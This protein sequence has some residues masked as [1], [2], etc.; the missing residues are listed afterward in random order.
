[1]PSQPKGFLK[2]RR[3]KHPRRLS[4]RARRAARK[5]PLS[6]ETLPRLRATAVD[7]LA[8]ALSDFAKLVEIFDRSSVSF[9][10]ITQQFNTTTSMGRLTLNLPLWPSSRGS[11]LPQD[12]RP[13]DKL[14][15][16]LPIRREQCGRV[17]SRKNRWLRSSGRRIATR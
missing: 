1:M 11:D 12:F 14:R 10:S 9:V 2:C 7:R 3:A 6:L 16:W 5:V 17:G 8:R 15:D 4:L 13:A